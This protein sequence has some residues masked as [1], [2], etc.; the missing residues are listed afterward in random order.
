MRGNRTSGSEITMF[1]FT[2]VPDQY[3]AKEMYNIFKEYG[4]IDEVIFP[5]RRDKRRKRFGFVRFFNVLDEILLAIKLDN[6][7]IES[8]K[9]HEN[10]Q[11]FIRERVGGAGDMKDQT[12]KRT[13]PAKWEV[14]HTSYPMNRWNRDGQKNV[15]VQNGFQR[16]SYAQ[17]VRGEQEDIGK[18]QLR[19]ILFAHLEHDMEEEDMIRFHKDFMGVVENPGDTY[20]IQERF[21][22][23]GYF[24]IK[25]APMGASLWLMEEKDEGLLR[26]IIAEASEW[27]S[28][29]FEKIRP[30]CPNDVDNERV[31]WSRVFSLPCHTWMDK[32]F[33]CISSP[34]GVFI[35]DD[36]D[37]KKL[38]NLDMAR[39]LVR[40]KY[41][42]GL[43]QTHNLSIN[44]DVFRIKVVEYIYGPMRMVLKYSGKGVNPAVLMG[45]VQ[46][47]KM[48]VGV[49]KNLR[50]ICYP[51]SKSQNNNPRV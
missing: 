42:L 41:C 47:R 15:G 40:T 20:N 5:P 17:T 30:W 46:R 39:I 24:G 3:G 28:Q 19:K 6:I 43:N 14:T 12:I 31:T 7:I 44:G 22:K 32:I 50:I 34:V 9:I 10:L 4:H 48:D 35:Y 16:R 8:R 49:V 37:T 51:L 38:K 33:K 23:E 18:K 27:I 36:E 11:R 45:R 26:Y 29:W 13:T 2:E 25:V 21:N 1:F